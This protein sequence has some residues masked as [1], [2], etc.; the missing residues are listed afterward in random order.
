MILVPIFAVYMVWK[1]ISDKKPLK[2]LLMPTADWGP[3]GSIVDLRSE[4]G[5]ELIMV[6]E[7]GTIDAKNGEKRSLITNVINLNDQQNDQE[8][9]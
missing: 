1:Q 8:L 4:T 5:V 3:Q 9:E 6:A 2:E 7:N